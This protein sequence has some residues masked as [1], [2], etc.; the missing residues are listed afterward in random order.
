MN[1]DW[2]NLVG[3]TSEEAVAKVKEDYPAADVQVV[4]EDS[5]VTMDYREDRVRIFVDGSNRVA[6][7][8]RPG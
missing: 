4:P 8:P 7:A 3:K 2:S 6:R 5:M 1:F